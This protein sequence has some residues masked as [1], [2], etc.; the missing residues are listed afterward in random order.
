MALRVVAPSTLRSLEL[1]AAALDAVE[2]PVMIAEPEGE[3][4]IVYVNPAAEALFA[5]H[6]VELNAGLQGADVRHAFGGSIH[7]FHR[8]PERV[9]RVLGELRARGG[10]HSA[11][12]R[13]GDRI[14][15]THV[16]PVH[17]RGRLVGYLAHWFDRTA[18]EQL[19]RE[20]A[21]RAEARFG[22]LSSGVAQIAAAVE[23]LR[24]SAAEV[25]RASGDLRQL[26]T[27]ASEAARDGDATVGRV[28]D[29]VG[30]L[31]ERIR[32][33]SEALT[34]LAERTRSLDAVAGAIGGIADQTNLL[35]LN[36][37]IEASR[38][39]TA[40]RGFAVVADEVRQ[41]AGRAGE[42]AHQIGVGIAEVRDGVS[43]A[44]RVISEGLEES[45]RSVELG[46]SARAAV[47]GIVDGLASVQ[48]RVGEIA[49]ATDQQQEAVGE[50]SG[51]LHDIVRS[52]GLDRERPDRR[53]VVSAARRFG[54]DDGRQG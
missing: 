39:G 13:I 53:E 32:S 30:V 33:T 23:E 37:A 52:H 14:L 28:I 25:A 54:L 38:A 31:S 43:E 9:R 10:S 4:T 50:I 15:E 16:R 34:A 40:G 36:A 19:A 12:I 6:A 7:R 35:A 17:D 22:E 5:E 18:I 29:A 44:V 41:L 11:Q 46:G 47:A 24:A 51:R 49:T 2:I 1:R 21:V 3:Q 45:E 48:G 8:D 27:S 42:L 20:E 26:A